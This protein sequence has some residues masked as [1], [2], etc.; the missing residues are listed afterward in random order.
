MQHALTWKLRLNQQPA[1]F[2]AETIALTVAIE[3]FQLTQM[4]RRYVKTSGVTASQIG[5]RLY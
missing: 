3:M 4:D 1:W 2:Y 5:P